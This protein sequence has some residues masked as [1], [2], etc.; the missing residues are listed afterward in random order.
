MA[1]AVKVFSRSALKKRFLNSYTF[2]GTWGFVVAGSGLVCLVARAD[3]LSVAGIQ[4]IGSNIIIT[5]DNVVARENYTLESKDL[6]DESVWTP[7]STIIPFSN[8]SIQFIDLG[9]ADAPQRFYR[10]TIYSSPIIPVVSLPTSQITADT[11]GT[12]F[13]YTASVLARSGMSY[14][15]VLSAPLAFK[16]GSSPAG[17]T[18]NGLNTITFFADNALVAQNTNGTLFSVACSEVNGAGFIGTGAPVMGRAYPRPFAQPFAVT[19]PG[20]PTSITMLSDSSG[21]NAYSYTAAVAPRPGMH[22]A[23]TVPGNN[24]LSLSGSQAEMCAFISGTNGSPEGNPIMIQVQ[25]L[26]DIGD[27]AIGTQN[28]ALYS[29]PRR[30]VIET[31]RP[32]D[33]PGS[34]FVVTSGRSYNAM[35]ALPARGG[36]FTYQWLGN[37]IALNGST[38]DGV[39]VS[40]TAGNNGPEDTTAVASISLTEVNGAGDSIISSRQ[41][42]VYPAPAVP[43]IMVVKDG[44]VGPFSLVNLSDN[45][46]DIPYTYNARVVPRPAMHYLWTVPGNNGLTFGN[47]QTEACT[48][49]LTNGSVAGTPITIGAQ[50]LNDI[51]DSSIPA[52]TDC[53][54]YSGPRSVAIGTDRPGDN[55]GIAFVV[56]A[57]RNYTATP[58]LPPRGGAFTYQWLG[59]N[60]ALNSSTIDGA[61]VSFT[62]GN[63]GPEDTTAVA[64]ISLTEVNGAGDSIISSRQGI[65]YPAPLVPTI[66]VVK[67]GGVGPFSLVN[68]SDN[69]GDIPYTYNARVVPRPAMHYLWTVP[70]NNGLTFGNSQTEACTFSLTNGSVAGTPITIGAQEL[71]DIGDSS[72]P[73]TT[74]CTVYSG[75]RSVAIGTDRPGDNPGIAFVV[76]AGRNYTATP[77]VPPRG[78]AFTYQWLGNNIALNGSTTDGASVSFTAGNN[79]PGNTPGFAFITLTEVNGAGDSATSSRQGLVY[80]APAV[81]TITVTKQGGGSPISTFSDSASFQ[82]TASATPRTG[83]Y[84]AWTTLGTN[85][86]NPTGSDGTPLDT[87][88]FY[89]LDGSGTVFGTLTELRVRE[90]NSIGDFAEAN[91]ACTVFS[92]PISYLI[93]LDTPGDDPTQPFEL[94][95]GQTYTASANVRG[96]ANFYQWS[97]G[98]MLITDPF[99]FGASI[100]FSA[101]T[102]Q[103]TL[104]LNPAIQL[105]ETNGA[106]DTATSTRTGSVDSP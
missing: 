58:G 67:D 19:R 80:S 15:W 105:I 75:P 31:D 63:N 89:F 50:E 37:N 8:G 27:S 98:D 85:P 65:V 4:K 81:P 23:W 70:G 101:A 100:T 14:H 53:T 93:S 5:V 64:S 47:S 39:S 25:E 102:D 68:L 20:S 96:G 17:T 45:S 42:I 6:L 24:S 77:G 38:T 60:I 76:T 21:D 43:T 61:S 49:N 104:P 44:G 92:A 99:P 1:G 56:T 18:A 13:A 55:P 10:V 51:G 52:T 22:Y 86:Q 72:I 30:V 59:N 11:D 82:Y 79:D 57:G 95:F 2:R 46:G 12:T 40:F 26:N 34:L 66:M 90:V 35:P 29:G 87:F 62:A 7:V 97:C 78:G 69:S 16:A 48:F 74:D 84:Y 73:A 88:D 106:G 33:D 54:V 32:G 91:Q 3:S 71:N 41:G 28:Y 94:A 83:M 36:A 103:N 9:G